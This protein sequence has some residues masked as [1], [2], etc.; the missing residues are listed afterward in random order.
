GYTAAFRCWDGGP[1]RAQARRGNRR[2]RQADSE[3]QR[4][5]VPLL[6]AGCV[7]A[8]LT[9]AAFLPWRPESSPLILGLVALT[10]TL[11]TR[12]SLSARQNNHLLREKVRQEGE[13][14]GAALGR[15]AAARFA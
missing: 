1:L 11:A 8:M 10:V 15:P 13:A 2:R 7:A 3:L 6:E 9:A 4:S 14:R 12:L 5:Q